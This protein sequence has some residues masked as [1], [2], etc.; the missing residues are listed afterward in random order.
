MLEFQLFRFSGGRDRKS[1]NGTAP[2]ASVAP[3]GPADTKLSKL[4]RSTF[5]SRG[6]FSESLTCYAQNSVL[7]IFFRRLENFGF[8]VFGS[9][10]GN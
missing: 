8:H 5:N 9:T 6:V 4:L 7:V 3:E 10:P 1:C 2:H